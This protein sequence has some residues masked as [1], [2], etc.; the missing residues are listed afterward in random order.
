MKND[1]IEAVRKAKTIQKALST[2]SSGS[3]IKD[4]LAKQNIKDTEEITKKL[5]KILESSNIDE[6]IET[7][8][9][10]DIVS[11][12]MK[13]E[14]EALNSIQLADQS[15]PVVLLDYTSSVSFKNKDGLASKYSNL[16][17][18]ILNSNSEIKQQW[19]QNLE[20]AVQT[21]Q[22]KQQLTEAELELIASQMGNSISSKLPGKDQ[23]S[24]MLIRSSKTNSSS[25]KF[26][27]TEFKKNVKIIVDNY[28]CKLDWYFDRGNF[29]SKLT[30]V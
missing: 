16:L 29:T 26:E 13:S 5:A 21:A 11:S 27:L 24:K 22:Q 14:E 28:K 18:E 2:I 6:K 12:M 15:L 4:Q 23:V 9:I 7:E 19:K 25:K 20:K 10:A 1:F 30:F 8:I 3:S 17:K